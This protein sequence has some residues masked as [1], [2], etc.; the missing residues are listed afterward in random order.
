MVKANFRVRTWT[1][2]YDYEGKPAWLWPH[3]QIPPSNL[4]GA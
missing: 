4:T 1:L 3:G 2:V